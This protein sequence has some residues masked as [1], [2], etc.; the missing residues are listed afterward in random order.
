MIDCQKWGRNSKLTLN[1]A[2]TNRLK[3]EMPV[4]ARWLVEE[5]KF[6]E[7]NVAHRRKSCD[8]NVK[9]DVLKKMTA[10]NEEYQTQ[11]E[12]N[13]W[14]KVDRRPGHPAQ[15]TMMNRGL[16]IVRNCNAQVRR[17]LESRM[18]FTY[19]SSISTNSTNTSKIIIK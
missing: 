4:S 10:G 8:W 5:I 18:Y 12:R 16:M 9:F 19:Q 2:R 1:V 15:R 13:A 3:T 7:T 17:S 14:R 11:K 6:V